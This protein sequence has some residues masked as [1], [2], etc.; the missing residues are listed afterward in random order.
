[1]TELEKVKEELEIY[2]YALKLAAY[3]LDEFCP[4]DEKEAWGCYYPQDWEA[5]L[6]CNAKHQIERRKRNDIRQKGR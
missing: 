4:D 6:W 5:E 1:M 3:E 2:K